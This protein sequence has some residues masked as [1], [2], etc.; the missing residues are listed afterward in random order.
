MV[1]QCICSLLFSWPAHV[2]DISPYNYAPVNIIHNRPII[3]NCISLQKFHIDIV[4]HFTFL[5]STNLWD[6]WKNPQAYVWLHHWPTNWRLRKLSTALDHS[7]LTFGLTLPRLSSLTSFRNGS[8]TFL[9]GGTLSFLSVNHVLIISFP[10]VLNLLALP[11]FFPIWK[12]FFIIT[13]VKKYQINFY[14]FLVLVLLSPLLPQTLHHVLSEN[15]CSPVLLNFLTLTFNY[16]RIMHIHTI[17]F[18]VDVKH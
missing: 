11:V 10:L 18:N 5:K 4:N 17:T 9:I 3:H 8:H 15:S 12:E 6:L 2:Q 13:N 7:F 16:F 1:I 14:H